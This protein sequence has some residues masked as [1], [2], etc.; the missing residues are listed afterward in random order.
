MKREL[1]HALVKK[2]HVFF[3]WLRED[4]SKL[5]Q[6]M[7]FGISCGDGWYWILDNLMNSIYRYQKFNNH[8]EG[9]K[10]FIRVT[11]IKEKFGGLEFY[12]TGGDDII[13]G[14]VWLARNLSYNTCER[15]GTTENVGR[16]KQGWIYVRCFDCHKNDRLKDLEWFPNENMRQKKLEKIKKILNKDDEVCL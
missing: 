9:N 12:F 8:K 2:Y 13:R 10:E 4:K 16:T 11:Q 5:I 7:Q 1:Q 14:M 6:P 15:C 3:D